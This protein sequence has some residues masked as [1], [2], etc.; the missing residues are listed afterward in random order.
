MRIVCALTAVLLCL[1]CAGAMSAQDAPPVISLEMGD[2]ALQ[3]GQPYEVSLRLDNAADIWLADVTISYDPALVYVIGT[4][5]GSPLGQGDL[6]APEAVVLFNRVDR[7][8]VR[9]LISQLAPADPISGGGVVARFRIYPLSAGQTQLTISAAELTRVTFAVGA[10]GQ[11]TASSPEPVAPAVTVL[12]LTITGETVEPPPEATATPTPTATATP[13]VPE[14]ADTPVP[15]ATLEV[16]T[17]A[18]RT[19]TPTPEAV[20][21]A[22][23][24]AGGAQPLVIVLAAVVVITGLALV[25]ML[26][27]YVRRRR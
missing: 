1:L 18:P 14:L 17:V 15:T 26:V 7:G 19:A 6:F 27:L 5:S 13:F 11:R 10:D 9:Y 2:T 23:E 8:Q 4:Q 12:D 16:V 22:P 24:D 25:A 21:A 20:S 3:T